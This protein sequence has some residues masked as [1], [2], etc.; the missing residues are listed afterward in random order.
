MV[1]MMKFIRFIGYI[2]LLVGSAYGKSTISS[3]MSLCYS[4]AMEIEM[5]FLDQGKK[6]PSSLSELQGIKRIRDGSLKM[7]VRALNIY[8]KFVIVPEAPIIKESSDI[9]KEYV[10][11]HLFLI[12]RDPE[13]AGIYSYIGRVA[14]LIGPETVDPKVRRIMGIF[15]KEK[16]AGAMI[17][18]IEGFDPKDQPL[19]F[20]KEL[21][22]EV[23]GRKNQIQRE[24]RKSVFPERATKER[25]GSVREPEET[26]TWAV[27]M[28]TTNR[29]VLFLVAIISLVLGSLFWRRIRFG[30]D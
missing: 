7:S 11:M 10:G 27:G 30:S 20:E 21:I 4:I 15:L 6:L 14:I 13:P 23:V 17:S 28:L 22:S 26:G 5:D 16:V 19:A 12:Q 25:N 24:M 1:Q 2:F 8:N 3:D 9:P 18:Q 29:V